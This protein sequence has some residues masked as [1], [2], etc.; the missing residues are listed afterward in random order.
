MEKCLI[1]VDPEAMSRV[2]TNLLDNAIKYSPSDRMHIQ[3]SLRREGESWET[4]IRQAR[5]AIAFYSDDLPIIV[6]IVDT[7]EAIRRFLPLLDQVI[8][9]GTAT[10]SPVHI[11]KYS[12]GQ[13]A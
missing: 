5:G 6:E 9:H 13:R 8:P 1:C 11:V 7:S 4:A 3:I 12:P 2:L 10:L